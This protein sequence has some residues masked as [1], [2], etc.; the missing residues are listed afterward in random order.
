[1]VASPGSQGPLGAVGRT[2]L[3]LPLRAMRLSASAVTACAAEA[4]VELT[5]SRGRRIACATSASRK[6][7]V[8][9]SNASRL[10]TRARPARTLARR[11]RHARKPAARNGALHRAGEH[12]TA[13]FGDL[14]GVAR[15]TVYR[16]IQRA[17][18]RQT[19]M[20]E[21]RLAA[22][23]GDPWRGAMSV[24]R[25]LRRASRRRASG[26][27]SASFVQHVRGQRVEALAPVDH[28]PSRGVGRVETDG[29]T[30][31]TV[32]A[33]ASVRCRRR[34]RGARR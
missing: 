23:A 33:R 15:S 3:A 18:R 30:R 12:S 22:A 28:A 11:P 34:P 13:E 8:H 1:M 2:D 24:G 4:P 19:V 17:E 31:L 10:P 6:D 20:S 7:G 14:F 32:S 25:M 27:A 26:A 5:R 21:R 9:A 29:R 16:A